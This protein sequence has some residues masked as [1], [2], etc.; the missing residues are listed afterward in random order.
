MRRH[1]WIR[2]ALG[3]Q[4]GAVSTEYGLL[5]MLIAL[6]I[7]AG[8]AVFGGALAAM[9]TDACGEFPGASC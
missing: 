8:A 2:R 7:I 6:V 3:P 1:W 4:T 9:F 5:L